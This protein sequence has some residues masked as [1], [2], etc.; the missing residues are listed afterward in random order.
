MPVLAWTA[1]AALVLAALLTV[2]LQFNALGE[3]PLRADGMDFVDFLVT[4]FAWERSL[5]PVDVAA[6]LL[7]AVAFL[8]LAGISWMLGRAAFGDTDRGRLLAVS[9]VAAGILGAVAQLLH[10]GA[11]EIA[12]D[13]TI[14]D[15]GYRAE[16]ILGRLEAAHVADTQ[17]TWLTIGAFVSGSIGFLVAAGVDRSAR[18]GRTWP[19]L[20]AVI[21]V[22][23]LVAVVVEVVGLDPA[24][25]LVVLVTAGLLIPAWAVGLARSTP[26]DA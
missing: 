19:T 5:M 3:P 21:G 10:V 4:R 22:L 11:V 8:S 6:S 18:W 2:A 17:R 14:C 12:T 9:F 20:S 7:F 23:L 1:A 16:E 24:P 13:P 26:A 25:D 15:C